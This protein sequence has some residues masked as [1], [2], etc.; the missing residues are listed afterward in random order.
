[1][2]DLA[3]FS[4][5]WSND[6]PLKTNCFAWN[7]VHNHGPTFLHIFPHQDVTEDTDEHA[8]VNSAPFTEEEDEDENNKVPVK[9]LGELQGQT[10]CLLQ[11][12]IDT[13]LMYCFAHLS[14]LNQLMVL[15]K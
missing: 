14:Q 9:Q 4:S 12:L 5:L 8:I 15:T 7:T 2:V 1:M 3:L 6:E 11:Y 10:R 13:A